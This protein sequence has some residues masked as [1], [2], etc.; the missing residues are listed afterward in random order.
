VIAIKQHSHNHDLVHRVA[1]RVRGE[2]GNDRAVAFES[3]TTLTLR[4]LFRG[5]RLTGGKQEPV[6]RM[7]LN[8]LAVTTKAAD[9]LGFLL[10]RARA[11][12]WDGVCDAARRIAELE[13]QADNM[14]REAVLTI[15]RGTF[16]S[17]TREDFLRLMEA[18]DQIVDCMKDAARILADAPLPAGTT[19]MFF[20]EGNVPA[21]DM[22]SRI[23]TGIAALADAI[24]ALESDATV[25][26]NKAIATEMAEEEA[27]EIKATLL[28][29]IA[30]YRNELNP[31]VVLQLRDFVLQLD[32]VAD[33][34]EDA[35]DVVVE[36]VAKA[37]A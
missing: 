37:E 26:M 36:L 23:R 7:I 18:N 25:A 13:T 11:D 28:G 12:D 5:F 35:S 6:V 31:L 33:A 17:G 20:G 16:F 19:T 29:R 14:H 10:D 30:E 4:R 27:D 2:R 3:W 1:D 15:A 34:A 22:V 9:E 24:R 21:V 32:N 8:H